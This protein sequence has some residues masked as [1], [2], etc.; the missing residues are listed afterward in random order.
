[1][2]ELD[3]EFYFYGNNYDLTIPSEK[4]ELGSNG[5]WDLAGDFMDA[6]KDSN[7]DMFQTEL[8]G[9]LRRITHSYENEDDELWTV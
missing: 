3:S 5:F 1:M 9:L 4:D 6:Y 2:T 7:V 8:Y